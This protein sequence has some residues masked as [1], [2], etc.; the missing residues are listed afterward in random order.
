MSATEAVQVKKRGPGRPRGRREYDPALSF[1][2]PPRLRRWLGANMRK[3]ES[4]AQAA[5]RFLLECCDGKYRA[6]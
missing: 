4:M 6:K 3:G 5:R 1:R 2:A